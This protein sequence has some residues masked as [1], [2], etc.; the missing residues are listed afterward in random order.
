MGMNIVDVVV[1]FNG[2]EENENDFEL[3]IVCIKCFLL[4]LMD[5]EEVVL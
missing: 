3:D 4:K 1:L 2:E 5:S